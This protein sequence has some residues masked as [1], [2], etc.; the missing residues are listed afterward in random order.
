MLEPVLDIIQNNNS[1]GTQACLNDVWKFDGERW[2][3]SF[4]N[5]YPD[6]QGNFGSQLVFDKN[7]VFPATSAGARWVDSEGNLYFYGGYS[8]QNG[9]IGC[10]HSASSI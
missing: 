10:T 5:D 8:T 4:G 6:S 7:N 3:W 2:L 9:D 1:K